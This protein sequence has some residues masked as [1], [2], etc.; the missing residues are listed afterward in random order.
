MKL[1]ESSVKAGT[2]KEHDTPA[3]WIKWAKD[4]GYS[5]AHLIPANA[6]I[7]KSEA[8]STETPNE[9][10][11]DEVIAALFDALPIT[12]LEKMFP[13]K[14]GKWKSWA[15]RAKRNGLITARIGRAM[16]NP[17]RAGLWFVRKGA[18]GGW[19]ES[20]LN[21]ALSNNLPAR[22]KDNKPLLIGD[23]E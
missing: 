3:N 16:F 14:E 23:M 4:K 9:G 7:A 5:V 6:P 20:R 18:E 21:R 17:Y 8:I 15:E 2:I 19:D 1:A 22:S 11:P 13:A 12:A 10:A